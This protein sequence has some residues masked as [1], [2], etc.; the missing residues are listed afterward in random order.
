MAILFQA[1][2]ASGQTRTQLCTLALS[3]LITWR[4][5]P[6]F[7]Q[8]FSVAPP[9]YTLLFAFSSHLAVCHLSLMGQ[10]VRSPFPRSNPNKLPTTAL[11][12]A[13]SRT[14]ETKNICSHDSC[15]QCCQPQYG[16]AQMQLHT[17]HRCSHHSGIL[18][19]AHTTCT[20]T[21]TATLITAA[22]TTAAS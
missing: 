22:P 15:T 8:L 9:P 10:R 16:Q 5:H 21:T 17:Q 19:T 1:C 11:T 6:L 12:M 2:S 3:F 20:L 4:F 18:T 7:I 14:T 13:S